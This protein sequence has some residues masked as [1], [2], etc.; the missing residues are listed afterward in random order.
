MATPE[1]RKARTDAIR[2]RSKTAT[3]TAPSTVPPKTDTKVLREEG[4]LGVAGIESERAEDALRRE[5]RIKFR[6]EQPVTVTDAAIE[7]MVTE[8][9]N[10]RKAPP[11]VGGFVGPVVPPFPFTPAP[12]VFPENEPLPPGESLFMETL[13]PQVRAP[14]VESP[15]NDVAFEKTLGGLTD[16]EKKQ[17]RLEYAGVKAAYERIRELN[18]E[19]SNEDI[20]RDL[21]RQLQDLERVRRGEGATVKQDPRYMGNVAVPQSG[22]PIEEVFR[23]TVKTGEVPRLEPGQ[24]AFLKAATDIEVAERVAEDRRNLLKPGAKVI[25][26][27]RQRP[28]GERGPG[29]RPVMEEY[30][31]PVGR[32]DYTPAEVSAIVERKKAAGEYGGLEWWEDEKRRAEVLASPEKFAKGGVLFQKEYPTGATVESPVGFVV[33][34]AFSPINAVAGTVGYLFTAGGDYLTG[35]NTQERKSADRPEKYRGTGLAENVLYNVREAGGFT[36]EIGD[37]YKYHPDP[38]VREYEWAGRVAG[39]GADLL[40]VGDMAFAEGVVGGVKAARATAAASRLA[41]GAVA[42]GATAEAFARGAAA[43]YLDSL[44]GTARLV[45]VVAPGDVRLVY[46]ARLADEFSAASRYKAAFDEA[47]QAGRP[48]VF[49]PAPLSAAEEANLRIGAHAAAADAVRSDRLANTK[50]AD[51]LDNVGPEMRRLLDNDYFTE[52]QRAFAQ[53][54]E[55]AAASRKLEDVYFGKGGGLTTAEQRLLKPYIQAAVKGSPTKVQRAVSKAFASAGTAKR[56]TASEIMAKLLQSGEEEAARSFASNLRKAAGF[57]AGVKLIDDAL[58]KQGNKGTAVVALTPK[59]FASAKAADTISAEHKASKFYTE[60]ML[61]VQDSGRINIEMGGKVVAG[62]AVPPSARAPMM[63]SI[64]AARASGALTEAEHARMVGSLKNGVIG[65][66]DLRLLNYTEVDA[67][68][69]KMQE[70]ISQRAL[71]EVR[72]PALR[73][74]VGPE[75]ATRIAQTRRAEEIQS[76]LPR[77]MLAIRDKWLDRS[78]S[79]AALST[80]TQRGMIEDARRQVSALDRVL[81]DDY[82]RISNETEFA[83]AYGVTLD[84]SPLERLIALGRGTTRGQQGKLWASQFLESIV[85]GTERN[86]IVNAFL[87]DY[88]YGDNV[89]R[90]VREYN[91]LIEDVARMT[92]QQTAASLDEIFA[93][94]RAIVDANVNPLLTTAGGRVLVVPRELATE[95]L[96]VAYARTRANLIVADAATRLIPERGIG[97]TDTTRNVIKTLAEV[98]GGK[99]EGASLFYEM[100]KREAAQGGYWDD[101]WYRTAIEAERTSHEVIIDGVVRRTD[102]TPL[103]DAI[104]D[105]LRRTTSLTDQQV[106]GLRNL[107]EG[108]FMR[109]VV[110]AGPGMFD[111]VVTHVDLMRAEGLL[112]NTNVDAAIARVDELLSGKVDPNSLILPELQKTLLKELGK[113]PKYTQLVKELARLS[114]LAH[115]GDVSAARAVRTVRQLMDAYHAFYYYVVLSLQPRFHGVNNFTAPFITYYTTGRFGNVRHTPEAANILLLGA[116]RKTQEFIATEGAVREAI[117]RSVVVVTDRLGNQYTRGD[118]FDL[119]VRNGVFRSQMDAEVGADFINEANKMVGNEGKYRGFFVGRR[120]LATPAR[121]FLG[122]PLAT[123]TDNV[124]RMEAVTG[125]LR[126]GKTIEEALVLGRRSLFDYGNLTEGER[127]VSRNVFVFYNYW[128]QSIGQFMRNLVENPMRNVRLIRATSQPT[129]IM[130]GE[131]RYDE[132]GF[133]FPPEF[134]MTRVVAKLQPAAERK[135]GTAVALPMMPHADALNIAAGLLTDPIGVLI[136]PM[137]VGSQDRANETGLVTA[138]LGPLVRVAGALAFNEVA[139]ADILEVKMTK[140]RI[141]PEHVALLM[142]ANPTVG[143]AFLDMFEAKAVEPRRG[144]N[145]YKGKA[146]ETTDEG[147]ERYK[148]FITAAQTTGTNRFFT[149]YGKIVGGQDL[150]G[151]YPKTNLQQFASATGAATFSAAVIDEYTQRKAQEARTQEMKEE[152]GA[153]KKARLP[154]REKDVRR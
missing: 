12:S 79:L 45:N 146:F 131:D 43:A 16:A 39:F 14:K 53:S 138:R 19:I 60:V 105:C 115:D 126:D 74:G 52:G 134:G 69:L 63:D 116:P 103:A 20:F 7:E 90:S 82:Q 65:A 11:F 9:M 110:E 151:A 72:K 77:W 117:D 129:R 47:M 26:E 123:F 106:I 31:V 96:A 70:G 15:F 41:E 95:A 153:L 130:V 85:Y 50:F 2:A 38:A 51:D 147:F 111:D 128:R 36:Q 152:A 67:L 24:M 83:S 54:D 81:R 86:P 71:A 99:P 35:S 33:R 144:E 80:A 101:L 10:K 78:K 64:S 8:E 124:W 44:P 133:Y 76:N 119:T 142:E 97:L 121:E 93:R 150:Q 102:S 66:D 114:D 5:L 22:D 49:P 154:K 30:E 108:S 88:K 18:P 40:G 94:T 135:Q 87:G 109:E 136:G 57:E 89:L 55:V 118:L 37:L 75:T 113:E 32:G 4:A 122:D 141:P 46:G 25:T 125:A 48:S 29:G 13:K 59:T 120:A 56:V 104:E 21:D 140:N 145:S 107:L 73:E 127:V 6:E 132:M 28:S 137:P 1:E 62:Y 17:R 84:A 100:V 143:T 68:A 61:P 92:P 58:A 98:A 23:R 27:K 139:L 149:D 148:M 3:P 34:Q 91:Q 42:R 112:H